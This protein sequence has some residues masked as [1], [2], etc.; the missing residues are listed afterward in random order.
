MRPKIIHPREILLYKRV[1]T[2][3][4]P[5]FGPTGKIEWASPISLKG[6]VKYNSYEKLKAVS[7]GN[8]PLSDGHIVFYN[9]DWVASEG[10]IGDELELIEDYIA[11]SRLIIIEIRPAA[12]YHG[13]NWH[14]HVYF[15]RKKTR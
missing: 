3:V 5:E 4:D 9:E 11:P 6:Q 13:R 12:H 15:S 2:D 10:K 1:Y 7:E 14:V 8:D